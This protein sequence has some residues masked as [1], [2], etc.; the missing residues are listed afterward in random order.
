MKI[1]STALCTH[2]GVTIPLRS[3]EG[4]CPPVTAVQPVPG[5]CVLCAVLQGQRAYSKLIA[6]ACGSPY[7]SFWA[8]ASVYVH[9]QDKMDAFLRLSVFILPSC[10]SLASS[11][12]WLQHLCGTLSCTGVTAAG[13]CH[14]ALLISNSSSAEGQYWEVQFDQQWVG[15]F[16]LFTLQL[17]VSSL[18]YTWFFKK[19]AQ[20]EPQ[21]QPIPTTTM[22]FCGK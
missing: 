6:A 10:H 14:T 9:I 12:T 22:Y 1:R 21:P 2:Q 17:L 7:C 8:Q 13:R 3:G 15:C 20:K 16:S 19:A 11:S 5:S 4:P 18:F